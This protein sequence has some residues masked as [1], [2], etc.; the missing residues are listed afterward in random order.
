MSKVDITKIITDGG[1]DKV[2]DEHCPGEDLFKVLTLDTKLAKEN[3]NLGWLETRVD[4][5]PAYQ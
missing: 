3:S 5:H 4:S 1:L 2:N